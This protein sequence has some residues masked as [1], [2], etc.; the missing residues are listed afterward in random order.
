MGGDAGCCLLPCKTGIFAVMQQTLIIR[1]NTYSSRDKHCDATQ[2]DFIASPHPL[3]LLNFSFSFFLVLIDS[4]RTFDLIFN[5]STNHYAHFFNYYYRYFSCNLV[6]LCVQVFVQLPSRP[7]V[8]QFLSRSI[9]RTA[10]QVL[11]LFFF[12]LIIDRLTKSNKKFIG[13]TRN[14]MPMRSFKAVAPSLLGARNKATKKLQVFWR[15]GTN[16][17]SSSKATTRNKR[18]REVKKFFKR[19]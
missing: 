14:A 19:K 9:A 10:V 2:T 5:Q 4:E 15:P 11:V 7:L 17:R 6:C 8:S 16:S 1:L 12:L 3:S 18:R 13:P